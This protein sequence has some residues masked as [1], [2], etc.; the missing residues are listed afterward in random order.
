MMS[1][2]PWQSVTAYTT[3]WLL[4]TCDDS[5]CAGWRAKARAAVVIRYF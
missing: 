5:Q 2:T 1:D 4:V 3:I